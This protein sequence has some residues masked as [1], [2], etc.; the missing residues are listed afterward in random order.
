MNL[1]YAGI[2]SRETPNKICMEFST[3]GAKLA[4]CGFLLRSGGADGADKAFEKGCK[5]VNGAKEI[6]LPWKGF[7]GNASKLYNPSDKA[8]EMARRFHKYFD[9]MNRPGQLLMARNSH[10]VF[11]YDMNT[12]SDFVIC[13]T[14]N[15]ENGNNKPTTRETGGTG[16]AIRIAAYHKIPIFNFAAQNAYG[17]LAAFIRSNYPHLSNFS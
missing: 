8:Y 16:Q 12:P 15:G 1:I 14:R 6:Y 11:G 4:R 13:W 7:N 5:S 2:G 10:Q 17:E 3:I 9:T